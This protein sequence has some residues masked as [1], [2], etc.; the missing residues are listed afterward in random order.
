[1]E[2]HN[3]VYHDVKGD[4][5]FEARKRTK[6]LVLFLDNNPTFLFQYR[7]GMRLV[8]SLAKKAADKH[9]QYAN[10]MGLNYRSGMRRES[11]SV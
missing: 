8:R 4:I 10:S 2:A 6:V 7:A 3:L 5:L 11:P 9:K 1:M